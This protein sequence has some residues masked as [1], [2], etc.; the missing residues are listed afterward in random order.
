MATKA[1]RRS[2]SRLP[3]LA[4][5]RVGSYIERMS[6]GDG[7]RRRSARLIEALGVGNWIFRSIQLIE[8]NWRDEVLNRQTPYHSDEE[9]AIL[10][11][12][13]GWLHPHGQ[14]LK[15]ARTLI[16]RGARLRGI[17]EFVTNVRLAKRIVA[18]DHPPFSDPDM[19]SRWSLAV[20][21][22]QNPRPVQ[23]DSQGRVAEVS[24]ARL[25]SPSLAPE[26]VKAAIEDIEM[27]RT[28][29]FDEVIA[30]LGL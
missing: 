27:G 11:M 22:S 8:R 5:N 30:E 25:W 17:S 6:P 16:R 3:L 29:P 19:L 18:G 1:P 24:G 21:R 2:E 14:C 28:R 15:E 12:Y 10:A 4:F 7:L 23:V 13:E 9:L 26:S 20:A